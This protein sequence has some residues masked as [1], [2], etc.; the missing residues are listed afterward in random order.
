MIVRKHNT[1]KIRRREN[2]IQAE[3]LLI[4]DDRSLDGGEQIRH[5]EREIWVSWE[6]RVGVGRNAGSVG[7]RGSFNN[8][9]LA[10]VALSQWSQQ[11]RGKE[12]NRSSG[13]ALV[14]DS[15]YPWK[16]HVAS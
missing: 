14:E 8:T 10:L 3:R 6:R 1:K 4:F 2:V 15:C 7:G 12:G 5:G 11:K 16:L 9:A 13:A